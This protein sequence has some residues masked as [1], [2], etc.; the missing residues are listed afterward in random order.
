MEKKTEVKTY[1]VEL[2]CENCGEGT[3]ESCDGA[4]L[5]SNPPQYPHACTN[6]DAEIHVTGTTYPYMEHK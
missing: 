4:V 3:M 2:A 5:T 6:C 1:K